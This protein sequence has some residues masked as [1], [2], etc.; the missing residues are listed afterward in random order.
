MTHY[1]VPSFSKVWLFLFQVG[2]VV[3]SPV[4]FYNSRMPKKQRKRTIVEELLADAEFR[5]Y[6]GETAAD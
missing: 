5:R 2:T 1:S 3:D 4:D 6:V